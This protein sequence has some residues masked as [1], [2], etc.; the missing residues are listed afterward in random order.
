MRANLGP[1]TIYQIA[2]LFNRAYEKTA[3][4]AI[5]LSGFR[6]TGIA[7]FDRDIFPEHLFVP[8]NTTDIPIR[9]ENEQ[10]VNL[11]EPS[12]S[13]VHSLGEDESLDFGENSQVT[14]I[15]RSPVAHLVEDVVALPENQFQKAARLIDKISPRPRSV[16]RKPKKTRKG[17]KYQDVLT[18]SPF[19]QEMKEKEASKKIKER[20][21]RRITVKRKI[22]ES[23]DEDE[24]IMFRN[25]EED[26]TECLSVM[27]CTAG[28]RVMRC[29]SNVNSVECG[30]T[31][32][33]R[34]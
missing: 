12:T 34:V 30:L 20:E 32:S 5:A 1:V 31:L 23:S 6:S 29:G 2:A 7:P 27:G 13:G 22:V 17:I 14:N 26:D 16:T 18:V 8:S 28:Q 9:D 19:M 15:N 21:N 33:A 10:Q 11:E 25:N 4:P 3:T 24:P